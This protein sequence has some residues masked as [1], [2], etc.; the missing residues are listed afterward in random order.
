MKH[1]LSKKLSCL[2]LKNNKAAGEEKQVQ[3]P[4]PSV[5][6]FFSSARNR[7]HY[8]CVWL[9]AGLGFLP[10]T[11]SSLNLPCELRVPPTT[12]KTCRPCRKWNSHEIFFE[13]WLLFC[14]ICGRGR[15]VLV[16]FWKNL[17]IKNTLPAE[18]YIFCFFSLKKAVA[19]FS[20]QT[21]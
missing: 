10:N 12:Q 7:K 16:F 18:A 17:H 15:P 11:Q 2:L 1:M 9:S 14:N 6:V 5:I 21:R 20:S 8:L 4:L 3:P 19:P 13:S